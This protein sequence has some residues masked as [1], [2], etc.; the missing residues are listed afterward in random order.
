MVEELFFSALPEPMFSALFLQK[1]GGRRKKQKIT[2]HMYMPNLNF[3]V[4]NEFC[5]DCVNVLAFF[6]ILLP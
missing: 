3:R 1:Y 5:L 4:S 6:C 2:F